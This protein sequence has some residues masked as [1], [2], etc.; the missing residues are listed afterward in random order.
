MVFSSATMPRQSTLG[1]R[2]DLRRR[3]QVL[4]LYGHHVGNLFDQQAE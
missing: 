4:A 1:F 2:N 3:L